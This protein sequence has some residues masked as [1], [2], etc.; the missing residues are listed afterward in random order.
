LVQA[1]SESSKAIG[2]VPPR[3]L[4]VEVQGRIDEYLL[5]LDI[6]LTR[7]GASPEQ[8]RSI[9]VNI[10]NAIMTRL[11]A[12]APAPARPGEVLHLRTAEVDAVLAEIGSPEKH[13]MEI[14]PASKA[15]VRYTGPRSLSLTALLGIAWG[16]LF[17]LMILLSGIAVEPLPGESPPW[18]HSALQFTVLPLGWSAPFATTVLGLLAI[19][20]I[21]KSRGRVYGLSLALFA[22]LLYPLLLLDYIAFWLCW[23]VNQQMMDQGSV[24]PSMSKLITQIVPTVACVLGDYFLTARA[25]M[26]VQRDE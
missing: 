16:M 15:I 10:R 19:G 20:Q 12:K 25:W 3:R 5:R 22:S 11:V 7:R 18:W 13:A 2:V 24:A 14:T 23:Q 6:A 21:Q 4:G 9:G 26:A 17:P 1:V 8:R